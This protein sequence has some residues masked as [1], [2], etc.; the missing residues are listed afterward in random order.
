MRIGILNDLAARGI[1]IDVFGNN[2]NKYSLH[3]N[4]HFKGYA[5]GEELWKNLRVYRVQLN[6]MRTHNLGS[7]NMRS[8]EIPAIGGI[9]LAP[10]TVDHR[11]FFKPEEEI[12]LFKNAED[13]YNQIAKIL[14]LDSVKAAEIRMAARNRC[15]LSGYSYSD[16]TNQLVAILNSHFS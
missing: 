14:S 1:E 7:H 10:D 13:C 16:R 15:L 3:R 4:I 12:F 9:Q 8:F 2:W 5:S 6:L 11:S